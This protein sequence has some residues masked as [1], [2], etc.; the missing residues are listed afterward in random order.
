MLTAIALAREDFALIAASDL[1]FLG[2][3]ALG[4]RLWMKQQRHDSFVTKFT[5]LHPRAERRPGKPVFKLVG[6]SIIAVLDR[7]NVWLHKH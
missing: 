3:G 4:M 2:F 5:E 7:I 1:F 6:E